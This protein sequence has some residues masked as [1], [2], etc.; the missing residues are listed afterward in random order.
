MVENPEST[1]DFDGDESTT[2]VSAETRHKRI[3]DGLAQSTIALPLLKQIDD[4]DTDFVH[5]V[6]VDLSLNYPQGLRRAKKVA[7][8]R[9]KDAAA[10]IEGPEGIGLHAHRARFTEQY[11]FASLT[12]DQIYALLEDDTKERSGRQTPSGSIYKIWLDHDVHPQLTESVS[13]IKVDAARVAFEADG[14]GIVWAVMD[15]GID[16]NHPHFARYDNLELGKAGKPVAHRDFSP[17]GVPG[18]KYDPSALVD[19][20]AHQ[21]RQSRR[22]GI[23][24][25]L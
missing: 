21:E 4:K 1:S 25:G 6:I 13:V 2:E 17:K 16:G 8:D 10:T 12:R 22:E 23:P 9:I 18:G 15:S 24:T 14:A 3:V 19:G 5:D 7:A 20:S 11:L